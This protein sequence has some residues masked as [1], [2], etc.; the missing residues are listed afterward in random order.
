MDEEVVLGELTC[1]I[2]DDDGNAA[3]EGVLLHTGWRVGLAGVQSPYLCA[4][5]DVTAFQVDQDRFFVMYENDVAH[6]VTGSTP[7]RTYE[8]YAGIAECRRGLMTQVSAEALVAGVIAVSEGRDADAMEQ[9]QVAGANEPFHPGPELLQYLLWQ[10]AGFGVDAA[11]ALVG[12][13]PDLLDDYALSSLLWAEAPLTTLHL[14]WIW[15]RFG[16]DADETDTPPWGLVAKTLVHGRRGD[17]AAASRALMGGIEQVASEFPL[18]AVLL[19]SVGAE[20][21]PPESRGQLKPLIQNACQAVVCDDSPGLGEFDE[22]WAASFEQVLDIDEDPVGAAQAT[23]GLYE[24]NSDWEDRPNAGYRQLELWDS[25]LADDPGPPMDDEI[26]NNSPYSTDAFGAVITWIAWLRDQARVAE[27]AWA[28]LRTRG[29]EAAAEWVGDPDEWFDAVRTGRRRGSAATWLAG[30]VGTE[31]LIH[32]GN[33][34]AAKKL[35]ARAYEAVAPRIGHVDDPYT[36]EASALFG[37]YDGLASKRP[38]AARLYR[39]VLSHKPGFS[40]VS[41]LGDD[42][43]ATVD[44][45]DLTQFERWAARAGDQLDLNRNRAFVQARGA[46]SRARDARHLRVVVGGETSAGKSSFINAL[47]GS[48]ILFVTEE[49]ATGVPTHVRRGERWAAEVFDENGRSID[50]AQASVA[51]DPSLFAFVKRYTFLGSQHSRSVAR[52]VLEA[53]VSTIPA[54]AE[55]IDTP[56]LNAHAVRTRVAESTIDEAH[57]CIFV[58][59][60]AN[61]LKAG[62]MRKIEWIH[63][64]V[65]RTIFVV[66]KMDRALG[67]DDLDVDDSA[68][69][70]VLA[71][72][73]QELAQGLHSDDINVF[74]VSSLSEER[75]RRA[76][77]LPEAI[78]YARAVAG[79]RQRLSQILTGSRD[80]LVAF[81]ASKLA[82]VVADLAL[83]QAG[84]EVQKQERA[85]GQLRATMPD[86]PDVFAHH[87]QRLV[88]GTWSEASDAYIDR[89]VQHLN[90]LRE[91]CTDRLLAQIN[92]CEGDREQLKGFVRN[93]VRGTLNDF[94]RDV[95]SARTSEWKHVAE[96]V[97]AEVAELFE[98]LYREVRFDLR[99]DNSRLL[100]VATDIPLARRVSGLVERVDGLMND[101]DFNEFGGAGA[102]AAAGAMIFGPL[103]ALVGGVL[104]GMAGASANE[105]LPQKVWEAVYARFDQ[106]D[107]QVVA[108]LQKDLEATDDAPAPILAALLDNVEEERA[109]FA[110]MI[111]L[112]IR[113]VEQQQAQTFAQAKKARDLAVAA[114]DWSERFAA[115]TVGR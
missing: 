60:A 4:L 37:L 1:T 29:P 81:A 83:D 20:F 31:L 64:A 72:V 32:Q 61:A 11:D 110:S 35:V 80:T 26:A 49:E 107:D 10:S 106:L 39:R 90:G 102:G 6:V 114:A 33:H 103:G 79:V 41:Q 47:L 98:A 76:G 87:V 97:S 24:R 73:R 18:G 54:G 101:A 78:D 92:A 74:A 94:V 56:G 71:R 111:H 5:T 3:E 9:F 59:D 28:C 99:F 58:F 27:S 105:D 21:I 16:L 108:A 84:A 42:S 19:G 63:D 45:P 96:I 14:Q 25:I 34:Q 53:P 95:Q 17:V 55:I 113:D 62:E 70:D 115:P 22:E 52:L 30:L 40:W 85:L 100:D 51:G 109:S 44:R 65:G 104:G 48:D 46:L 43:R 89:M 15:Q 7:E 57:A 67:D 8:F 50:R 93:R 68:A 38:S 88:A 112:R 82:R 23:V 91:R 77:F 69:E 86:D 13:M 12:V 2:L 66:N 75:M 36:R